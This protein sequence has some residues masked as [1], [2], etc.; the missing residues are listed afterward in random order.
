MSV[1]STTNFGVPDSSSVSSS[2]SGGGFGDVAGALG[3][4]VITTVIGGMF[5]KG[6]ADKARKL[7][8]ELAKLSL[9]QQKQLEERLQDVKSETERQ[10]MIYQFLAVQNNNEMINRVKSKR[11]TSYIVLGVGVTILA[12][13]VLKLSKK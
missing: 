8:K 1:Y 3:G 11:Y 7:Q 10:G 5:A 12:L 4:A 9:A 13:V 2:T 6:E